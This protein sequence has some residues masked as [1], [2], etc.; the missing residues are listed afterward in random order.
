MKRLTREQ[1][2]DMIRL[3]YGRLVTAPTHTAYASYKK[4]GKIFGISGA[5]AYHLCH[6]RF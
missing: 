1:V 2:E 3:R 6:K 5:K 4:L